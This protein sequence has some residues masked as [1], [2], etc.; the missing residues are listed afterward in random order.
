MINE[1]NKTEIIPA[2]PEHPD[3]VPETETPN[4]PRKVPVPPEAPDRTPLEVPPRKPEEVPIQE[5]EKPNRNA[6]KA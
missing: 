5:P 4:V 1:D 6:P 2:N 3:P